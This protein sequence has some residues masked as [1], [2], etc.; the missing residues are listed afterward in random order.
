MATEVWTKEVEGTGLT[1]NI[2]NPGAP[3]PIRPAPGRARR[4]AAAAPLY[5]LARGRQRQRLALRLWDR[6]LPPA[7]AGRHAGFELY[8]QQ[9]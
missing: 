5:R 6:S 3:A 4:D 2:A 9:G 8:P 1:I 7:E